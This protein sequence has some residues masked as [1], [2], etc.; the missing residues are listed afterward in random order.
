MLQRFYL[1]CVVLILFSSSLTG[2]SCFPGQPDQSQQEQITLTMWGLFDD[3]EVFDPIINNYQSNNTNIKINYIKKDYN[4]YELISS[5][6][7]ASDEGPDIWAIQ[8]DW[9]ARD[10]KKIQPMPSGMLTSSSVGNKDKSDMDI[11][12]STF[13]DIVYTDN[14]IDDKI[15]GM[16]LSVDTLA[17]YY[18][19]DIFKAKANELYN[20][21]KND[22]A[23]LFENPPG[24]WDTFV[25]LSKMLTQKNGND[26][27]VSGAALGTNNNVDKSVD[28]LSALMLQNNTT[29]VAAD[30]QSAAFNLSRTKE[31]GGVV[32]PGTNALDFYTS[33]A[34][35]NKE[36]Y[37]WNSSMP[38]SVTAFMDGKVAMMIHYSYIQKRISQE[39]PTLNYSIGPL[40]QIKGTNSPIDYTTYWTET[41][42]KNSKHPKEAWNFIIYCA[43][44]SA[45]TYAAATKRPAPN[46]VDQASV[47]QNIEERVTF[48]GNLFDFQKISAHDWYKG[49]RPDKVNTIFLDMINNVDKGQN[50]QLAIDAAATAVTALLN[51]NTPPIFGTITI[52][53]P[54]NTQGQ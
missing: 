24:D 23:K 20:I 16:P 3:K 11:Y 44:Q 7:L 12:K 51:A 36:T 46:R 1:I 25:K 13:P 54:T 15:Y 37:M 45:Q 2:A 34:N 47:P 17:L 14:V 39:K 4:E 26:I 29:M 35:P 52:Q 43:T 19:T 38:D 9:M 53:Q 32:Y 48:A 10:Y 27:T 30:K 5:E 41:V 6:A 49:T 42:T 50:S 8:N 22:E 33:F 31:S 18:N 28:I 40:P 21:N